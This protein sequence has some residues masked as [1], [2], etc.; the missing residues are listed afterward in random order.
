MLP[1]RT[2]ENVGDVK[3]SL[4]TIQQLGSA[5]KEKLIGLFRELPE[6][7]PGSRK[8]YCGSPFLYYL[9]YYLYS[10]GHSIRTSFGKRCFNAENY[11]MEQPETLTLRTSQ[12]I[13]I[14]MFLHVTIMIY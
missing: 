13:I 1:E 10:E 6:G 4:G 3:R 8:C 14:Y 5:A 2:L 11:V 7:Q 9:Y 12:D